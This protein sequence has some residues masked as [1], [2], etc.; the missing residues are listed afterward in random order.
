MKFEKPTQEDASAVHQMLKEAG[1]LDVN[2]LYCYM[3]LC[4]QFRETCRIA[5]AEDGSVAGFLSAY[6]VPDEPQALFVW[7][8]AVS[9]HFRKQGIAKRL[10]MNVVTEDAERAPLAYL[11]AT[12]ADSNKASLALFRSIAREHGSELSVEPCFKAD[13]FLPE[14]HEAEPLVRIPLHVAIPAVS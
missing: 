1:G 12:V 5:R 11:T 8:V 10:L 4:S 6:R 2:T 7:Q 13:D 9:R 14:A 3:L